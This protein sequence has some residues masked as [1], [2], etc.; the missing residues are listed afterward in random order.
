MR[1]LARGI[2]PAPLTDRG[3]VEALRS[4]AMR[5]SLPTTVLAAGVGRYPPEIETAAYFCCLEALQ[6]TEKHAHGARAA[7]VELSADGALH[8][9]IRDDGA[10][11]D[12]ARVDG[13]GVGFTSMRDRMAAVGGELE[14]RSRPGAGTQVRGTDPARGYARR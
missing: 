2:Y 3:L 14:I 5:T 13:G 4:A 11:F 12:P 10:G 9:E 1:S 6:N 7:V 8:L